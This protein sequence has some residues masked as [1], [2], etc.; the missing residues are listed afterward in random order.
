MAAQAG[1]GTLSILVAGRGKNPVKLSENSAKYSAGA[2]HQPACKEKAT[3]VD[4]AKREKWFKPQI[5]QKMNKHDGSALTY[6]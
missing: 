1:E 2:V 3:F 6:M 5:L 4:L